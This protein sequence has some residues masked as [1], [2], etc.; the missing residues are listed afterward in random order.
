MAFTEVFGDRRKQLLRRLWRAALYRADAKGMRYSSGAER[1]LRRLIDNGIER[2]DKD[3]RLDSAEDEHRALDHL[4]E[5][6]DAVLAEADDEDEQ[7]VSVTAF[8]TALR[9]LS[10][11]LYPF[12]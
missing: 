8:Q 7:E 3:G 5:I 10:D 6:V 2:L 11:P 4:T 9:L 1:E 12:T